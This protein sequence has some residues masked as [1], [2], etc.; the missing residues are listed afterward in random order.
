MEKGQFP[1]KL[2]GWF[3]IAQAFG[4]IALEFV[5]KRHLSNGP[6]IYGSPFIKVTPENVDHLLP[7]E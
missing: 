3:D 4:E 7:K 6:E 1:D 2:I 5:T